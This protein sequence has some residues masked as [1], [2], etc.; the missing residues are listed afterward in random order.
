MGVVVFGLV[1][2][3]AEIIAPSSTGF[4]FEVSE[5]KRYF[6]IESFLFIPVFNQRMLILTLAINQTLALQP[7]INKIFIRPLNNN[8]HGFCTC[9]NPHSNLNLILVLTF[10]LNHNPTTQYKLDMHQTV[11]NYLFPFQGFYIYLYSIS[12]CF[13]IY[14]YTYL[15]QNTTVMVRKKRHRFVPPESTSSSF[16]GKKYSYDD[17]PTYHTGSFYLRLGAVGEFMLT[18]YKNTPCRAIHLRIIQ[19]ASIYD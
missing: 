11:L 9:I 10:N 15:L 14:A 8:Y 1:I 17:S 6:H 4:L 3:V 12:I 18:F 16:K 5:N 13:L 19:A 2:P 7:N